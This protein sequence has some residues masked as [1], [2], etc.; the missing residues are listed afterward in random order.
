MAGSVMIFPGNVVSQ[1]VSFVLASPGDLER[2]VLFEDHG[3]S[4]L[5][6]HEMLALEW[7]TYR[8][9]FPAQR[10]LSAWQRFNRRKCA[11]LLRDLAA[12]VDLPPHSAFLS[13]QLLDLA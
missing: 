12:T 7:A 10:V 1:Y 13:I 11:H 5:A 6:I 2:N 3:G 9:C 4:W 8:R